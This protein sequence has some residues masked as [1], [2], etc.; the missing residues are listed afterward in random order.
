MRLELKQIGGNA[1][2]SGAPAK[3]YL[4]RGR[5][6]LGRSADCDWQLPED[7]R[8]VSKLHCI[9]ERDRDGFVLLDKSANGSRVNGVTVH[10][11]ETARLGDRSRLELGGLAF[12][13]SISGERAH[14]VED[15]DAG[16]ALSD[17]PLTI[18]AILADISSG[19]GSASGILGEREGDAWSMRATDAPTGGTRGRQGAPSS[20]NVEIGWDGPPQVETATKLLPDDWH[21]D[22]SSDFGDHLEH[23]SATRVAVPIARVRP[24]AAAEDVGA[25]D[26]TPPEAVQEIEA[27]EFTQLTVGSINM[28]VDTME[29]M[30][31]RMEEALDGAYQVFDV[32]QP[33]IEPAPDRSGQSRED[34]VA[35]RAE[36][37]LI[38]QQRLT[39]ALDKLMREASRLMEPRILEARVDASGR[40]LPWTRSRDYWRAY[41]MQFEKDGS[42]LSVRDIFR[43]AMTGEAPTTGFK[44]QDLGGIA[45][46]EGKEGRRDDEK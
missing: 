9:I 32:E 19:G 41:R 14:D 33:G 31:A 5:R 21:L 36:A 35:S 30:L 11:G 28:L 12:A 27:T 3:W 16:I 46:P 15:P 38:R 2:S 13:V 23:G 29:A 18:S 24:A 22:G 20:R 17:E 40:K 26:F 39:D 34:F 10:E 4:E 7:Q 6:T 42:T 8:S 45:P 43:A 1:S 44:V 25:E 37:L